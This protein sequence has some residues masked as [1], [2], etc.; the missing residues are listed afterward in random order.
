MIQI[1]TF[2]S[3]KIIADHMRHTNDVLAIVQ[4]SNL[5]LLDSLTNNLACIFESYLPD[6]HEL[7]LKVD[8]QNKAKQPEQPAAA[9]TIKIR[10]I[11]S[12]VEVKSRVLSLFKNVTEL[13]ERM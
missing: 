2:H 12:Q 6:L 8:A 1:R 7:M 4:N 5:D 13:N 11:R 10:S 9:E 3:S